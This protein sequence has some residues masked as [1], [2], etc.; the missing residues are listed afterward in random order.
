M[1]SLSMESFRVASSLLKK[2]DGS[3]RFSGPAPRPPPTPASVVGRSAVRARRQVW[4]VAPLALSLL[5]F[6][7]F[8]ARPSLR[9]WPVSTVDTGYL[10][11][12]GIGS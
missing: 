11:K 6:Q 10:A 9:V 4:K 3:F 1:F 2:R 12:P 8:A 5:R 7:P